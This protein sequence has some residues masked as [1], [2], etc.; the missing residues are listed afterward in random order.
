[1]TTRTATAC[2]AAAL[3]IASLAPQPSAGA[4]APTIATV[5]EVTTYATIAGAGV[6]GL[7]FDSSGNLYASG[8]LAGDAGV[9]KIGPGGSP[10]APLAMGMLNP[11]GI[12]VD[13]GGNVFVADW[14]DGAA[15]P[16][17]IW[18]V[19]PGG[20]KSV[21]ASVTSPAD[22]AFDLSGNLL[23][24]EWGVHRIQRVTPAG[25]VSDYAA[26][27]SGAGEE[28][29]GLHYD[30]ASGDL[31]V[32]TETAIKKIG[33]GGSPVTTIAS[34]LV[35]LVGLAMG[36]AGEFYLSR[37]SHRDLYSVSPVGA[38]SPYA[39]L[40]LDSD[41]IDGPLLT[42]R[43]TLPAL[44]RIRNNTLYIA[45]AGCHT[46]RTIDLP[47]ATPARTTSWGRLK[48]IYR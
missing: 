6:W 28:V 12:A 3:W 37:Y 7:G 41:C 43:F 45:D 24:S 39:G 33:P 8:Q 4:P 1:M 13:A 22:L 46:V 29:G 19:T 42:A 36:P 31:Y 15:I 18:K 9:W 11:K 38:A 25:V 40:H 23:V 5:N 2:C 10:I 32:E 34:G 20:T 16:A 21:F 30:A 44:L 48:T 27:I 17:K 14:G 35:G 47:G 26:A